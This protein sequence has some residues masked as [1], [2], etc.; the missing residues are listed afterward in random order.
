MVDLRTLTADERTRLMAASTELETQYLYLYSAIDL[1]TN[2]LR[3]KLLKLAVAMNSGRLGLL[4][5]DALE[6]IRPNMPRHGELTWDAGATLCHLKFIAQ[7]FQLPVMVLTQFPCAANASHACKPSL[8]D[9][10]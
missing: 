2:I 1:T 9:H 8:N 10:P 4:I 6:L 7:E 5:V 3:R